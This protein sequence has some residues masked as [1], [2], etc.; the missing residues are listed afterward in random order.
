MCWLEFNEPPL[1][2]AYN[3]SARLF[4]AYEYARVERVPVL[5]DDWVIVWYGDPL[6]SHNGW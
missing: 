4:I 6:G 1:A 2:I 5:L 3:N